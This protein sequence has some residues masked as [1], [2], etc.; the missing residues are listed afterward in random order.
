MWRGG[1]RGGN[2]GVPGAQ[3]QRRSL[4][5]LQLLLLLQQLL[6]P[7]LGGSHQGGRA[8]LL[9]LSRGQAIVRQKLLAQEETE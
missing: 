1:A 3:R 6:L 8:P 5:L 2:T 9:C 4:P 7:H